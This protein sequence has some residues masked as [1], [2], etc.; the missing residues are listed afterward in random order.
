MIPFAGYILCSL[1]LHGTVQEI[2]DF[3]KP[4][5]DAPPT[6]V[7]PEP[8]DVSVLW[9][10]WHNGFFYS[11]VQVEQFCAA[12]G[13]IY[14]GVSNSAY[15]YWNSCFATTMYAT[16]QKLLNDFTTMVAFFPYF[17]TF[18]AFTF[19]RVVEFVIL[20]YFGQ[21]GL[22]LLAIKFFLRLTMFFLELFE[23]ILCLLRG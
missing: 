20:K 18:C 13:S 3:A 14:A 23:P 16:L 8:S 19:R 10:S 11:E 4:S 6:T 2:W 9:P 21:S 7:G 12:V 17:P 15:D 22:V 1:I 5:P